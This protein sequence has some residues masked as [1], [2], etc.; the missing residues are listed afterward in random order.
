MKRFELAIALLLIPLDALM[1]ALAAFA[2]YALRF[3]E[4]I[5][6]YRPVA[7]AIDTDALISTTTVLILVWL[8]IFAMSGL[9]TIRHPRRILTEIKRVF[10]ASVLGFASITVFIFLRGELFNSRFI[11]LVA[12]VFAFV[13]VVGA[14]LCVRLVKLMFY[15][16]G[17][18]TRRVIL[19]GN[20]KTTQAIEAFISKDHSL[21]MT[22]V[23]RIQDWESKTDTEWNQ[24]LLAHNPDLIL[25]GQVGLA[26]T[27]AER[28]LDV[29]TDVHVPFQ[30][31]ADLF[32]TKAANTDLFII[33]DVPVVELK[34]TSLDGW[35]R[36]FKRT[37]DLLVGG[38][39][40]VVL[41]PIMAVIALAIK[42]DSKG[43]VFYK[44]QRV[45]KGG[46]FFFVYKFR[47][48]KQEFCT[49]PGYDKDGKAANL[50]KELIAKHSHRE[51]PLYKISKDPRSTRVGAFLEKTSLD[52]L[53]QFFNVLGGTMSLVGPR[54]HQPREVDLYQRHQKRVLAIKPGVTGLAQISGRSDLDFEE[55]VRLDSYYIENWSIRM[56]LAVLFKTP[57][58]MLRKHK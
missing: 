55:E 35:G 14:R 6:Q 1:L 18:G 15:R 20:D 53:P 57:F 25:L 21:G 50:E 26:K 24:T 51:G 49:G 39:S 30:Y 33:G 54:P 36:I 37:F 8:A 34:R 16:R 58:A 52:E 7:F 40:C 23:L 46:N 2:A 10:V 41:L 17:I 13:F 27:V 38:V 9:Y 3:E 5:T 43:P 47:R 29:A 19:V 44:N 48:L 45:G 42:L 11:V 28:V 22:V 12:A 56:D 32:E 31:A 4:V